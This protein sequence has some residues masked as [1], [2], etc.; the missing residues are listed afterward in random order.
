MVTQ[1]WFYCGFHP[2]LS[3]RV[4]ST[5]GAKKF[6]LVFFSGKLGLAKFLIA[7]TWLYFCSSKPWERGFWV[8]T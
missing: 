5:Y 2:Q 6:G 8:G 3:Y 7:K 4:S 1:L